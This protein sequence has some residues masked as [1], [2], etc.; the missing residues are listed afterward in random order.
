VHA[1]DLTLVQARAALRDGT[2]SCVAYAQALLTRCAAG[3]EFNAWVTQ[4]AVALLR[5]AA[6]LD[7][8]G[9]ARDPALPLAGIPIALKDNIDTL[10][11]PTSGGT[12]ALLGRTPRRDAPVATLL[13]EAGALLAGKAN[14]HELAFGISSNNTVTGAVRN[15]WNPALI[16]GGSSGGSAA[17]VAARMVPAAIGTDTGASVRLPAALCG[18]VGFRP[19][20]GRYPGAGIVPISHTRDTPGAIARS[21]ADVALIDGLLAGDSRPLPVVNLRG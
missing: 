1:A 18:V 9:A 3:S 17:A 6:A 8:S 15:P 5:D 10:A 20:V 7:A 14:M 16:P 11:L 12:R 21:V 4:D 13:F 19:T 2:L